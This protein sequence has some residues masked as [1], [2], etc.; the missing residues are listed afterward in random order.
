VVIQLIAQLKDPSKK[1]EAFKD[2]NDKRDL[3][4]DLAPVLSIGTVTILLQEIISIYPFLNPP[5]LSQSLSERTC[6]VLGLFQCIALHP[7]TRPYF[8]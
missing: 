3:T 8:L 4:S 7:E 1:D 2:L 5:T 6:S